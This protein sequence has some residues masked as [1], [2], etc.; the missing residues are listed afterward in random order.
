[1]A[2]GTANT[3]N[4]QRSRRLGLIGGG[5][6]LLALHAAIKPQTERYVRLY[7][8][9]LVDEIAKSITEHAAIIAQ[10][11]AGSGMLAQAAVELNWR[12]AASR[13]EQVIGA[14]GELGHW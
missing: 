14:Q 7:V 12:N 11:A 4:T 9:S 10:V 13:L 5:P 3:R 2:I 8:S 1:M 6:R